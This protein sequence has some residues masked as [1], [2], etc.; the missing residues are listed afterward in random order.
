M[1]RR[2]L[3]VAA[4]AAL[5]VF[6]LAGPGGAARSQAAGRQPVA[7]AGTALPSVTGAVAIGNPPADRQV[8]AVV[9]LAPRHA[10][11]LQHVAKRTRARGL[12]QATIRDL[13]LPASAQIARVEGYLRSSGL[14]V[15]GRHL[16]AI[17]VQGSV[18][19]AERAFGVKIR[20]YRGRNGRTFRA[21]AGPTRLPASIA[22]AVQAVGGLDTALRL[23]PAF[24]RR[25]SD[26]ASVTASCTGTKDQFANLAGAYNYQPLLT[27]GNNGQNE[28]IALLEFSN[29]HNSDVTNFTSCMGLT[30]PQI[31]ELVDGGATSVNDN[32]EVTL[33]IEVAMAAAP[34]AQVYVY[35]AP[36]NVADGVDAI[37]QMVA[38]QSGIPTNVHIL[39]DSWGLCEPLMP[40]ALLE[41]ENQALQLAAA[42]G[43]ST[44]VASGDDG[45]SACLHETG[46][47]ALYAD[48]PS[49]QPFATAV[50]GTRLTSSTSPPAET[51]WNNSYGASGGGESMWWPAP[52]WQNGFSQP[53]G[54]SKCNYASGQCRQTPDIALDADPTTGYVIYTDGGWG[55]V[56]GTSGA[57]P[58]MAGIT[59]DA[60]QYSLANGGTRLGFAN[61]FLYAEASADYSSHCAPGACVL[62]DV[63]TGDNNV[64]GNTAYQAGAEYDLA[65][66]LGSVNAQNIADAL[67]ADGLSGP[68]QA[69]APLQTTLTASAP[70]NKKV[71][72]Y[73]QSVS[74]SGSSPTPTGRSRTCRCT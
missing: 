16:L 15:T 64:V 65:T 48:D 63:T 8:D 51:T 33:D 24:R 13:F 37:N 35:K 57:A 29:Y 54:H 30:T 17:D 70:V 68:P 27:G 2:T 55:V 9:F 62:N 66:G 53:L 6:V 28:S 67:A 71:I 22:G 39:S 21:P 74:F 59:A 58:L 25:G 7:M 1:S 20:I 52:S 19:A 50:G 14:R 18:A 23:Q 36:N 3:T 26:P 44:Y 4:A 38:D 42:A 46:S 47:S 60:N 49:A 32:V 69:P 41:A 72:T 10:S 43:M 73:G 31:N 56:G 12:S 40:P 34:Q 11:L 61:P 45:S 5:A